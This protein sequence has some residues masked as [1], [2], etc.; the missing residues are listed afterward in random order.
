MVGQRPVKHNEAQLGGYGYSGYAPASY[1][2]ETVGTAIP[3]ARRSNAG[4]NSPEEWAMGERRTD[5]Y[6]PQQQH[7]DPYYNGENEKREQGNRQSWVPHAAPVIQQP[8]PQ[9][10]P[11]KIDTV[12]NL[13]GPRRL[14]RETWEVSDGS[15]VGMGS[16]G[17]ILRDGSEH[18]HQQA[19]HAYQQQ[20]PHHTGPDEYGVGGGLSALG[21]PMGGGDT[22]MVTSKNV[23]A[24]RESRE[25]PAHGHAA[26]R[27]M[28]AV[29]EGY[30]HPRE[31]SDVSELAYVSSTLP[32]GPVASHGL[33]GYAL[34]DPGSL[35]PSAQASDASTGYHHPKES[36][37]GT[38]GDGR[39]GAS[40]HS[41]E[42]AN[43]GLE[44]DRDEPFV[45]P[46]RR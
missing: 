8:T 1:S 6:P 29:V 22:V 37:G 33:R 14:D 42:F 34:R 38:F 28:R 20:Q 21:A 44:D 2:T 26:G 13:T 12:S 9:P 16:W 27:S 41:R 23:E 24:R 15:T 45:P 36:T 4:K 46:N 35:Q 31:E 18:Q 39:S 10:L 32:P 30:D 3:P 17:G 5:V 25:V 43:T 19:S 40:L 7:R 11:P